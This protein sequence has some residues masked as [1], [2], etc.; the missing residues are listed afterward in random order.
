M[1]RRRN[2]SARRA[3][4]DRGLPLGDVG[5]RRPVP[6]HPGFGPRA[7]HRSGTVDDDTADA[8]D[9]SG[10]PPRARARPPAS[11]APRY[12]D[13]DFSLKN[14]LVFAAIKA[15]HHLANVTV[16]EP[17]VTISRI[18][19]SLVAAIRPAVPNVTTLSLIE[20][21]ARNCPHNNHHPEGPLPCHDRGKGAVALPPG[22][23]RL[24]AELWHRGFLGQ[25]ALRP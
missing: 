22:G 6:R 20:G 5:T 19:G 23:A 15:A 18:T 13:L 25:A 14:S 17:P 10:A 4:G 2:L 12:T 8:R 24:G 16:P 1:R 11:D 7:S 21:N 3:T 9:G